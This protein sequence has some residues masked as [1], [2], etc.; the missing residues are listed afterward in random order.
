MKTLKIYEPAL[1]CET[2][3][4]GVGVD[5]ELLRISTV[6]SALKKKNAII[7]RYNLKTAPDAFVSNSVVNSYLMEKG[8]DGLPITLLDDQ[9][10]MIGKYPSNNEILE[11]LDLPSNT[12]EIQISPSALKPNTC[13]GDVEESSCCSDNKESD[14]CCEST[15]DTA[16]CSETETSSC[17]ADDK[18]SSCCSDNNK[19][20]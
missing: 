18:Q 2:G 17:C 11:F 3:V 8:V 5:P 12:L 19:C 6:L 20:Y 7:E 13:C 15:E 14:C 9:I 16:C 10:I 1:C 4:C